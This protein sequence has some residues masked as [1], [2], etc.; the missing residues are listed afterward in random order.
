MAG[1]HGHDTREVSQSCGTMCPLRQ[2]RLQ[3]ISRQLQDPTM[4]RL[5]VVEGVFRKAVGGYLSI[6]LFAGLAVVT[7]CQPADFW[8]MWLRSNRAASILHASK[9]EEFSVKT[10]IHDGDHGGDDFMATLAILSR[11]ATFNL[12]GITTCGGNI[13]ARTAARNAL[14]ACALARRED[15]PVHVGSNQSF[16]GRSF[17]GDGAQGIDGVGG[18]IFPE[19]SGSPSSTDA[20]TWLIESLAR[21][22][23]KVTIF[24]TGPLTN[25]A[26][27]LRREPSISS[28]IDAIVIMGGAF[29]NPG[30]NI[31]P[32]A[33]FNFAM[34]PEAAEFVMSV[35]DIRRVLLPLDATHSLCFSPMLQQEVTQ[36]GIVQSINMIRML[37]AAEQYDMPRFGSMGAFIHDPQVVFQAAD[38]SIYQTVSSGVK[39]FTSDTEERGKSVFSKAGPSIEVAIKCLDPLALKG[40]FVDSFKALKR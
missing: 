33:E 27:A 15:V 20:V 29:G 6:F 14:I 28:H 2:H 34:D 12:I 9:S 31:T 10:V 11:P 22:T 4:S 25:I 19:P 40:M 26:L 16:T 39:I 1:M 17:S 30:G 35:E 21:S 13:D 36:S 24:A 38:S 37:R 18:V 23:Q 32:H 5:S 7:S 8:R 3:L